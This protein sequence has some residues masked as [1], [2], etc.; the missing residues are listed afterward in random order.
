MLVCCTECPACR[1][2]LVFQVHY[3][4]YTTATHEFLLR[5]VYLD[6]GRFLGEFF[7]HLAATTLRSWWWDYFLQSLF[8]FRCKTHVLQSKHKYIRCIFV[9]H[10]L[11]G[12]IRV[13]TIFVTTNLLLIVKPSFGRNCWFTTWLRITITWSR[14]I[15]VQL[16]IRSKVWILSSCWQPVSSWEGRPQRACTCLFLIMALKITFKNIREGQSVQVKVLK[17]STDY[18]NMAKNTHM[19]S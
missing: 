10:S 8:W 17:V 19:T 5:D 11:V 14:W 6:C 7:D 1:T 13:T 12:F 18:I 16:S 3:S 2:K 4:W 15:P 9:I